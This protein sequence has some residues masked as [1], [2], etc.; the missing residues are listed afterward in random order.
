MKKTLTSFF[1]LL[2]LAGQTSAQKYYICDGFTY[3]EKDITENIQLPTD[4]TDIDSITFAAPQYKKV[5]IKYNGSSAQV[6]IAEGVKGVTCTSGTSSH[7]I[8]N[9]TTTSDEYLYTLSG[10][11]TDGSLTI[12]GSY[13]L[14]LELDGVSLTS[15]K[16]AAVDI[17]CGKR[18]DVLVKEG[19]VNTF[20]D[21]KNGQQKAAFYTKGHIEFKGGGTINITG[22]TKHALAA[23]EYLEFKGSFGTANILGAVSDG[24][25]CGK[26]EKGDSENNYFLINGG[27][28]TISGCGSDCIDTDDYGTA[29]IKG[30]SLHMDITQE[31]GVGL[32]TD[33]MIYMT[34]GDVTANVSGNISD[35]IRCSYTAKFSGG[36]YTASVKGN[37]SRGIRGKKVSVSS[38]ATV[39]GGGNLEFSG[40][41][42]V[43]TVS[44][45]TNASDQTK[46]FGIKADK[47]LSQTGGDITI[48]VTNSAGI[49]IKAGTDN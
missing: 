14:S 3:K 39:T 35:G 26:G 48:D 18:I 11:S 24:I 29:Y 13:K 10:T 38:T 7:V 23:K 2:I 36:T 8:L 41:N 33:S 27:N 32:K 25:H 28:I 30:G 15:T 46:C 6:T 19:T 34:G 40:T 45:G 37:G 20:S 21:S 4:W 43:M 47:I 44:G 17:E 5:E 16:G 49:D 42:V 1:T 22:N 9:S 12:N 31:D